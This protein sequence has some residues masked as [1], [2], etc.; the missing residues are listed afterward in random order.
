[1]RHSDE[2]LGTSGTAR[3]LYHSGSFA[4]LEAALW[5]EL[6]RARALEPL[7]PILVLVPA[8]LLRR[9]LLLEAAGRGGC[10]NVHFLT[11]IDLARELGE[12]PLAAAGLA[13]LPAL[14]AAAYLDIR[15]LPLGGAR[16][17]LGPAAVAA[18]VG[19]TWYVL[20]YLRHGWEFVRVVIGYYTITRFVGVVEGQ[21]GPW[22][23]YAP[24][25]GIGAFP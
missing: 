20:E 24:V 2:P 12:A 4:A 8:N 19:G 6:D 16:A 15:R 1:M 7:A 11:L 5:R 22:W 10:L 17:W 25:F 3:V 13:P 14:V 18:A 23:Y 9:H 21:A